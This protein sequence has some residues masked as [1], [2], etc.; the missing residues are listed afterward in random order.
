VKKKVKKKSEPN[1][2]QQVAPNTLGKVTYPTWELIPCTTL[3]QLPPNLVDLDW[4]L[5]KPAVPKKGEKQLY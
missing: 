1:P 2:E 3:Y 5:N 4:I